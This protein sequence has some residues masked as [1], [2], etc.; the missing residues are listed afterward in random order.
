[1]NT[2]YIGK[3]EIGKDPKVVS[4]VWGCKAHLW[5]KESQ[6]KGAD[7]LEV[8]CDLYKPKDQGLDFLIK[9]LEKIQEYS[10]LPTIVTIRPFIFGG[11][12]EQKDEVRRDLFY[13][14]MDL[15]TVNAV[16]IEVN[17]SLIRDEIIQH[18]KQKEKTVVVSYHND[19]MTPSIVELEKIAKDAEKCEADIIKIGTHANDY[20]DVKRLFQFTLNY[21]EQPIATIATGLLG[22]VSRLTFPFFGSCLS[23]GYIDKKVDSGQLAVGDLKNYLNNYDTRF[24]SKYLDENLPPYIEKSLD[25]MLDRL[26]A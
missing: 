13:S 23:Y 15:T 10:G 21:D 5:A 25:R 1:M 14:L 26:P 11:L 12:Y 9:S 16:D 6:K 22:K 18:A 7:L 24:I 2:R 17:A 20:A 4:V 19:Y 8:R 3:C